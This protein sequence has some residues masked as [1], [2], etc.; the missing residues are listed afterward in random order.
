ML[1]V[2]LLTNSDDK[3]VRCKMNFHI[4]H[5]VL[6]VMKLLFIITIIYYHYSK[7][8]PK[9]RNILLC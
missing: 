7:N 9:V 3:K 4:L 1:R 5:A 6:L 2:L 8:K